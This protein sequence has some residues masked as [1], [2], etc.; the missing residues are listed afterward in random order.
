M[1][2]LQSLIPELP[3]PHILNNYLHLRRSSSELYAI[4]DIGTIEAWRR[5]AREDDNFVLEP[6]DA[7]CELQ[8]SACRQWKILF[9]IAKL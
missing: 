9:T 6:H 8:D 7:L 4:Y 3:A 1:L 2:L 5:V